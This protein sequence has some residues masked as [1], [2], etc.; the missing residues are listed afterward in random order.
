MVYA[1]SRYFD[2]QLFGALYGLMKYIALSDSEVPSRQIFAARVAVY[3]GVLYIVPF[4]AGVNC[5][6]Y[7]LSKITL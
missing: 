2:T 4:T 3:V 1:Y 7:F 6:P 5:T